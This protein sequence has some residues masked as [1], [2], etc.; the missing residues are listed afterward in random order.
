MKDPA[1]SNMIRMPAI[2]TRRIFPDLFGPGI[3][4][5][6]IFD[7]VIK[8]AGKIW[9]LRKIA[10]T[11]S[12]MIDFF[13]IKPLNQVQSLKSEDTREVH[14]KNPKREC[15]YPL[16]NQIH[17]ITSKTSQVIF[18]TYLAPNRQLHFLERSRLL[19]T[20]SLKH[21]QILS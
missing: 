6:K 16:S 21:D 1:D 12:F 8:A 2:V 9:H 14:P 17:P 20:P 3:D 4:P 10:A 5:A 19:H 18:K 7:R 13:P 15:Q 11:S